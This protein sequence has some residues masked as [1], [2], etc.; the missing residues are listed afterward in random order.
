MSSVIETTLT[1]AYKH[2]IQGIEQRTVV[3]KE[4]TATA[5]RDRNR[6]KM[7]NTALQRHCAALQRHRTARSNAQSINNAQ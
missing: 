4:H 5:L 1:M 6:T 7:L 3:L 2:K